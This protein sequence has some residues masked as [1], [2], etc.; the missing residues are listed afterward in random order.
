MSCYKR[1]LWIL[2]E[3]PATN[4][5]VSVEF[6]LVVSIFLLNKWK[7]NVRLYESSKNTKKRSFLHFHTPDV[8]VLAYWRIGMIYG[9]VTKVNYVKRTSKLHWLP[10]TSTLR[11]FWIVSRIQL[12][13]G[14]ITFSRLTAFKTIVLVSVETGSV[15]S[16]YVYSYLYPFVTRCY[17]VFES[18]S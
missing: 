6:P 4:D 5:H 10:I 13:R 2:I 3:I 8:C 1:L 7:K 16:I 9:G 15:S 11:A 18:F 14:W 12:R 17:Y